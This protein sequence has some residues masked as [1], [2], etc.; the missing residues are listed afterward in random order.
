MDNQD[1][2]EPTLSRGNS[3][4]AFTLKHRSFRLLSAAVVLALITLVLLILYD[5]VAP[6]SGLH[7][8]P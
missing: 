4:S 2:K 7:I 1:E 8:P 3:R 5:H 6:G